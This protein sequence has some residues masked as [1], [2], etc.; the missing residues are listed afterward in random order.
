M[1]PRECTNPSFGYA[2]HFKKYLLMGNGAPLPDSSDI[3][4][5]NVV[6]RAFGLLADCAYIVDFKHNVE[7]CVTA[8]IY[9]NEEDV[10]NSDRYQYDAIGLPFLAELGQML[11]REELQREK[12]Y[13]F[14]NADLRSL[15]DK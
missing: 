5:F 14:S 8:V 7:F 13:S 10:L 11:Y 3:R 15:F 2:D 4:I 9:C 6:G 1:W 12:R